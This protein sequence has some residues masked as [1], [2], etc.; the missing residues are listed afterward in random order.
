MVHYH[1]VS[2]EEID[3]EKLRR[4]FV[5]FDVETT[6][7]SNSDRIIELGAAMFSNGLCMDK[8][9]RLVNPGILIPSFITSLTGITQKMIDSASGEEV[10]YRDFAFYFK[11][12]LNGEIY[13]VAHN[14]TFDAKFISNTL[15]R[16]GYEGDIYYVDTLTLSRRLIKNIENHKLSTVAAYFNIINEHAHRG[17][18]DA[19]TCGEILNRLLKLM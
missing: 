14:A 15:T 17:Y 1:K 19:I 5:A 8:Y 12:V 2:F 11:D 3:F 18:D 7:I 9:D 16:L 13:M 4:C 10:V 6:G